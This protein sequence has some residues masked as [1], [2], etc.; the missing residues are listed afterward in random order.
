MDVK[1]LRAFIAV[2]DEQSFVRGSTRLRLVPSPTA[3]ATG[4]VKQS[5]LGD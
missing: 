2:A 3:R 5:N 4:Q 1:P